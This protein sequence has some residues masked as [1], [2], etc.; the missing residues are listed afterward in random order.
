M[1]VPGT[2]SRGAWPPG[3]LWPSGSGRAR[4]RRWGSPG[5]GP[6]RRRSWARRW[7]LQGEK[8]GG[9]EVRGLPWH[10][11]FCT[12]ERQTHRRARARPKWVNRI[13]MRLKGHGIVAGAGSRRPP[14]ANKSTPQRQRDRRRSLALVYAASFRARRGPA[15]DAP[16]LESRGTGRAAADS[17]ARDLS[18]SCHY[19]ARSRGIIGGKLI[20]F[21]RSAIK[22]GR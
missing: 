5:S 11:I 4:S 2:S 13:N 14:K 3:S 21:R 1:P 6:R 12:N 15:A 10:C 17:S 16:A 8:R 7:V 19:I 9:G 22:S 20:I 18:G